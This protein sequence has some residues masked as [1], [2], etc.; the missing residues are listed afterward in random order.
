MFGGLEFGSLCRKSK[1]RQQGGAAT[2]M[3]ER[4]RDKLTDNQTVKD[5]VV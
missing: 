5:L 2:T 3:A 1:F 4:T